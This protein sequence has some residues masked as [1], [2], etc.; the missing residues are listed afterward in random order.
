MLSSAGASST[1][2]LN[3]DLLLSL[4]VHQ[5]AEAKSLL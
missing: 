3:D 5:V 4:A 1:K 2:A